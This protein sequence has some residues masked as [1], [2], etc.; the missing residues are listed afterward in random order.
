MLKFIW[1]TV[2]FISLI[3]SYSLTF[4]QS[5]L[6]TIEEAEQLAIDTAPEIR[7]LLA[8]GRALSE[9][10]VAARQL[11]DPKLMAGAINVPTN[12]FSFTQD[13]MTMI[14]VGLQQA[15]PP[16]CSLAVKSKQINALAEAEYKKIKD[17]KITLLRN[18][19]Q[20]WLD[21]YYWS[22]AIDILESNQTL[23]QE[24]F[25]V[26]NSQ[27]SA[28]KVN[29]TDVLQVQLELSRL[30]DQITQF[31]QQLQT[32]RAQLARWIGESA[33]HPL[34]STLPSWSQPFP[35]ESLERQLEQHPLLKVDAAMINAAKYEVAWAKE[36]YKPGLMLDVSYGLRQ[37][38][39]ADGTHRSDMLTANVTLDLPVFT[40]NRQDRQLK[41]SAYQL[42]S[43]KFEKQIHYKDL[44]QEL[45]VR[46]A[47][48]QSLS[49]REKLYEQELIPQAKQ[50]TKAALITYQNATGDLTTALRSVSNELTI[51]LEQL[52]IQIER[53][54]ARAALLY[55][56]EVVA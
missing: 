28:N 51:R 13:D 6:L 47:T 23:F 14:S 12:T 42:E 30:H 36:Q 7:K 38:N 56:E 48:W 20:T 18:V 44:L 8:D 3:C 35:I 17:Q 4:A 29:Q 37:G 45:N 50:N 22:H 1:G 15:F 26:A 55:F 27:Y 16:G 25:Q 2:F 9:Q 46:Y 5:N 31:N 10:A 49:H 33:Y 39:M 32:T 11:P 54:K 43:K 24:L 21:L 19:R 40:H 53:A 41:S 34:T 52:Q